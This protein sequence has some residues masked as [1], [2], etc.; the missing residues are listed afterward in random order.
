MVSPS[1]V[2][3]SAKINSFTT[4]D[5]TLSTSDCIFKSLGPMP[6]IGEIFPP[7]TWYKPLN[8]LVFSIAITSLMS[9]TTQT[10]SRFRFG[11]AQISQSSTSEILWQFLQN[12]ISLLKFRSA[13]ESSEVCSSG[14]LSKWS[15]SLSAVRL[16]IPG[17]W[18]I[19]FT[20]F[21]NNLEENSI[22]LI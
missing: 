20:A 19:S 13:S 2:E 3:L 5:F 7:K 18:E 10:S 22:N 9:S 17:S 12:L 14:C 21:S 15:A 6:S 16:P 11:C 8:W 1:I 4:P